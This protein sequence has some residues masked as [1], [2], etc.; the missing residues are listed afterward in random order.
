MTTHVYRSPG[1]VLYWLAGYAAAWGCRCFADDSPPRKDST[2]WV[3]VLLMILDEGRTGDVPT[4]A[5]LAALGEHF[6]ALH[7]CDAPVLA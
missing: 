4:S 5:L 7:A 6:D 3:V 1:G 2:G